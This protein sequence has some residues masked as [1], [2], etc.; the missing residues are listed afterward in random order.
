MNLNSGIANRRTLRRNQVSDLQIESAGSMQSQELVIIT[1]ASNRGFLWA[2]IRRRTVLLFSTVSIVLY[3]CLGY[4]LENTI[5]KLDYASRTERLM[6]TTPLVD[7]H[8]GLPYLLRLELKNKINDTQFNFREGNTDLIR[9]R[10]G[11]VGG[12]LWSIFV[13]VSQDFRNWG[14]D[15]I[16]IVFL[17]KS[18]PII[19]ISM[20]QI[21]R[22]TLE[23]IDVA[24]S[25]CESFWC[26]RAAFK[27]GHIASMVGVEGVHQIE[28]ALAV[29]R[30]F[31][32]LGI[33][34]NT[35]TQNCG[36]PF[37]TTASTVTAMGRD[38]GLTDMGA[39]AV[40]EMNRL[41]MMVDLS[42]NGGVVM[43]MFVKRFLNARDP[44]SADLETAI[45]HIKWR[46]GVMSALVRTCCTYQSFYTKPSKLM[47]DL[48][49]GADFDGTVTL[50]NGID[51]VTAYPRLIAAVMAR[52]ATDQQVRKLLGENVLC[53]ERERNDSR[54][55]SDD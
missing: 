44:E 36:N 13:E 45:D 18:V 40:K 11:R 23:Q 26:A 4:F 28:S 32:E 48:M 21:I 22:D 6:K 16:G 31:Y 34:Y 49:V 38:G 25:T 46:D 2:R 5:Y 51:D 54:E 53:V 9:M 30:Q 50:A 39:A 20:S 15:R 7:R 37:A 55:D 52:G 24:F 3:L 42:H 47:N 8:N 41:G 19:P 14:C 33:R 43:I 12:Q 35:F 27:A 1:T 29:V 10:Q 17:I